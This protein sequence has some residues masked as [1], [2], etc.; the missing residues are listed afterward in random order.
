MVIPFVAAAILWFGFRKETVWWE[1]FVPLTASIICIAICKL[2][3]DSAMSSDTEYWG[4]YI[5]RAEY[6]EPWNEKVSC[7]HPVYCTRLVPRTHHKTHYTGTGANRRSHTTSYT[8]MELE[9]Y[10][11]GWEHPFDVDFHA[12]S[13]SKSGSNGEN[14]NISQSEFEAFAAK[15]C[16]KRKV[17]LNRN[18]YTIDGNKFLSEWDKRDLTIDILTTFHSYENRVQ[19]SDLASKYEETTPE[20]VKQ[21]QLQSYPEIS[22]GYCPSVLGGGPNFGEAN[23]YL[24]IWNAKIGGTNQ[25]RM[26][27]LFFKDCDFKSAVE[28]EAYWKGGNKNEVVV[29]VGADSQNNFKWAHVFSWTEVPNFNKTLLG[30]IS[31]GEAHEVDLLQIAKTTVDF[32]RTDWRRKQF[33]EYS[34]LSVIPSR[35]AIIWTFIITIAVN[36]ICCLIVLMNGVVNPV[37]TSYSR[38]VPKNPC[39]PPPPQKRPPPWPLET[40]EDSMGRHSSLQSIDDLPRSKK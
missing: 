18:F 10:Q 20:K 4:G 6:L 17:E 1:L 3:A 28:Q 16:N 22:S 13:Y 12:A 19:V 35:N 9:R 40:K 31:G 30:K 7:R 32:V 27:I 23:N 2:C 8:S 25:V 34:Y 21:Y 14:F 24:N 37:D 36:V 15:N 11:C 26:W 33:K 39:P 5:T 29:C 38:P